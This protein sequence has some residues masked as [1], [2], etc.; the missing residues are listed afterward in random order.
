MFCE[1]IMEKLMGLLKP[2]KSCFCLLLLFGCIATSYGAGVQKEFEIFFPWVVSGQFGL[3]S[4]ETAIVV[5]NPG[6]ETAA[7][8]LESIKADFDG[9]H[10]FSLAPAQTNVVF[11]RGVQVGAVHV[12]S[13]VPVTASSYTIDRSA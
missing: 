12:K 4:L 8:T 9:P 2:A 1:E 6:P 13:N 7:V 10:S 5:S 11:F 3:I